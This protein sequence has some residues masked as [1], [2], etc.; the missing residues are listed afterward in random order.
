M[1]LCYRELGY[2]ECP[3]RYSFLVRYKV[4]FIPLIRYIRLGTW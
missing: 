4:I 2:L 3:L 1:Y